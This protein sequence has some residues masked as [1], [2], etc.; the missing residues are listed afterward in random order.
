MA[1]ESTETANA[2]EDKDAR[3]RSLERDLMRAEEEL[4]NVRKSQRLKQIE[5][6]SCPKCGFSMKEIEKYGIV[7]DVCQGCQGVYFDGGE[8]DQLIAWV[9]QAEEDQGSDQSAGGLLARLFGRA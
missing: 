4:K 1:D 9:K 5:K 6:V 2:T 8:V 7:L 3:I